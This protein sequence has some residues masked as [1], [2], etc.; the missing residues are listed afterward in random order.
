MSNIA[1]K[2]TL[3][4]GINMIAPVAVEVSEP[5]D[6]WGDSS[7]WGTKKRG[8]AVGENVRSSDDAGGGALIKK[9]NSSTTEPSSQ[10]CEAL[11]GES[12]CRLIR[13]GQILWRRGRGGGTAAR[14]PSRRGGGGGG[15]LGTAE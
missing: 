15:A 10:H 12:W 9:F 2:E 3:E 13:R 14:G 5:C 8:G 4:Q 7:K 6:A 11:P 1:S